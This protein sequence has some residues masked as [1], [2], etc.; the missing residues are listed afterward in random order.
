MD[1]NSGGSIFWN[2]NS[3]NGNK[4]YYTNDIV[5][6]EVDMISHRIFFF[7]TFLQQPVCLTNIPAILKVGL[8]YQPNN[9]SQFSVFVYKLRKP[10]ADPAKS[11]TIKQ[12]I[13]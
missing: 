7:H 12:W 9:D 1:Y 11:P 2:G 8:T 10:L 4:S 13:S 5:G 3:A 6:M